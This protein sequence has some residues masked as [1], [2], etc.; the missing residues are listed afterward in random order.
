MIDAVRENL[1]YF[2][3]ETAASFPD[4]VAL[5]DLWN[6]EERRLTYATL[7]KRANRVAGLLQSRGLQPG[8]RLALL[9]GNRNEYIEIFFGAMR[10]GVVPVPLNI[11]QPPSILEFMIAD[12]ECVAAAVD[13]S[14]VSHGLEIVN[15]LG[16]RL[17]I[18][19]GATPAGWIGYEEAVLKAPNEYSPAISPDGIAFQPFTAGST[20]RPKGARL[21]HEGMLWSVRETQRHWPMKASEV[22]LV[23]VPLFHKN[24]MRGTIKPALYAGAQTVIMPQFDPQSFLQTAARYQVTFTGGV[25]AIFAMLLQH[26][27]LIEELDLSKLK[28]FAIGSAVVPQELIGSLERAFPG[29]KVK[30]S[31]GLTEGGGPLREPVSG[32][33]VPRGSCGAAAEGYEVKL[34]ATNGSEG[35]T[36]GEMWTRSPTVTRG[37]HNLPQVTRE[38]IID[39]WLRTGDVFRVDP[40]G[41]YYFMGRIDDMFSCG[42]ENIYPKEVENLLFSHPAVRDACVVPIQHAVK[43]LVPAAAVSLHPRA[44]VTTEE[45]K[46]FCLERGPAYA[47]PRRIVIVDELPL[48]GAGKPDR[49]AIQKCLR[50]PVEEPR[51]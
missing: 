30:E 15:G 47:H 20:G 48:S 2:F 40:D 46:A 39:G 36:E 19:F 12:A 5:I 26:R 31:Y 37:Y 22:G 4:R 25:P 9:V 38:K 43:G 3:C 45:L 41:F 18:V 42:G 11:K 44:R 24:A 27:D 49:E 14:S 16:L 29:V 28:A 17:R 51:T 7:D 32:R 10:A 33:K 1:G 8:D 21:S 35:V 34:V 50:E 23:A 6:G 13:P